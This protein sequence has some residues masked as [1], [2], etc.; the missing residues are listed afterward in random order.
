VSSTAVLITCFNRRDK[1]LNCLKALYDCLLPEGH[2]IDVYLVDDGC[3]D[4]TGEAVAQQFPRVN[5]IRGTGN[6][7]WNRGMY[8]AWETAA[9]SK[10]YDFYLW[11]NDDAFL[12]AHA[13]KELFFTFNAVGGNDVVVC[14]SLQ[15]PATKKATYGGLGKNGLLVPDGTYQECVTVNGNCVLI[16]RSVF[17]KTGNLDDC[18]HHAIGDFDYGYRAGKAGAKI[19]TTSHF[20]GTCEE[21]P[22]L[23][24]WC[25]KEVPLLKRIKILYSPLGYAEPVSFFIYEKRHLGFSVAMKHFVTIHIRLIFPGLWK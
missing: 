14:A 8:L 18:F 15:S 11:L 24:K 16:P 10:N 13:I 12:Y 21:N 2:A 19:Y 17:Q 20:V 9:K 4:G 7:F 6:L 1:T 25:I 5:I 3:T 23:P 22:T